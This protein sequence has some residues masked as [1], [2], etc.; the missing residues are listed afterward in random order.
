[1]ETKP[2]ITFAPKTIEEL[3]PDGFHFLGR[4][5]GKTKDWFAACDQATGETILADTS[6][7]LLEAVMKVRHSRRY[8]DRGYRRAA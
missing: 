1:M 3:L 4:V 2:R 6:K 8:D 5:K 7:A